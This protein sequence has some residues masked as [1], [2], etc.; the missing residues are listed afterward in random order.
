[1]GRRIGNREIRIY[2][3]SYTEIGKYGYKVYGI[4]SVQ[5]GSRRPETEKYMVINILTVETNRRVVSDYIRTVGADP[6]VCPFSFVRPAG[7]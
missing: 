6:C 3:I 2:G 5:N 7:R 4:C 1:L